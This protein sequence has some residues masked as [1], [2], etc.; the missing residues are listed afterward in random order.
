MLNRELRQ[1]SGIS[2]CNERTASCFYGRVQISE[3]SQNVA[4]GVRFP[5]GRSS[6]FRISKA[7]TNI[8]MSTQTKFKNTPRHLS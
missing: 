5:L 7:H 2:P 4:K 6:R 8:L 1:F 3:C